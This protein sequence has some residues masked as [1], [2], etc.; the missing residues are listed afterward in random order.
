MRAIRYQAA[1]G[2]EVIKLEQAPVPQPAPGEA[3]YRGAYAKAPRVTYAPVA[4]ARHFV[5]LDQPAA[6]AKALDDF[7]K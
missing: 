1:G 2:P 5:M 7:L 6:F 3:L 4:D